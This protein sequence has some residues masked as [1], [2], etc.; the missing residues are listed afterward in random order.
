MARCWSSTMAAAWCGALRRGRIVSLKT[1]HAFDRSLMLPVVLVPGLLC[2]A[3]IF[4]PQVAALWPCGPVTVASTLA[5]DTI[6]EIAAA[7][8]AAAPPRFALAGISMGGYICLE[9]MRQ[10]PDRVVKLALLDTSA[11]PDTP[12]QT[13]KRRD[14]VATA[15]AGDFL[16]QAAESALAQV[17]PDSKDDGHL[18]AVNTRMAAAVGLDGYARQIE[19][20]IARPD[21]RPGLASIAVPTLVLVGDTDTLTP[22]ELAEELVAG[23]AK[24]SLTVVPHCGHLSTLEQPEAVNRA[25]LAWLMLPG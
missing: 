11:R 7:I 10:A 20:I 21:S 5:G 16:A 6:P 23:I 8:L 1:T 13:A 19:A 3:E 12:E 25:L 14:A 22:P 2:S 17:H 9:I 4:A 24:A 18:R 15:R